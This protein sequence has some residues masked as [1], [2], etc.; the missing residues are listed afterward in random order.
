MPGR[1]G[2]LP[3]GIVH[4]IQDSV[5][6]VDAVGGDVVPYLGEVLEGAARDEDLHLVFCGIAARLAALIR[7]SCLKTSSNSST[8]PSAMSASPSE[9]SASSSPGANSG[10]CS[11]CSR[12]SSAA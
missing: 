4:T 9:I 12:C 6:R 10:A 3:D 5:R 2:D 1:F 7:R 8:S 11:C